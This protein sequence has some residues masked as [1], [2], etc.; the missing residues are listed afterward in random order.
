M[1]EGVPFLEKEYA[2]PR[3]MP[4]KPAESDDQQKVEPVDTPPDRN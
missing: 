3:P 2:T 4:E 1:T